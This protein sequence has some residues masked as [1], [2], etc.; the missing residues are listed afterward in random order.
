MEE[1]TADISWIAVVVGTILAMGMGFVM[2]DPKRATGKIW[3]EGVGVGLTPPDKFPAFAMGLNTLGLLGM[4][5]FVGVTAKSDA[6][7]TVI[8]AT[9]AFA[10]LMGAHAMFSGAKKG[11]VAVTVSYWLISLLLMILSQGLLG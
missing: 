3:A 8:L 2:F 10:L 6:L 5:W 11:A 7:L 1:I 4:S 9:V